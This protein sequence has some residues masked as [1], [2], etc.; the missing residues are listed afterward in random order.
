MGCGLGRVEGGMWS[1]GSG[2]GSEGAVGS[3]RR[4]LGLMV[5]VRVGGVEGGCV[6]L[7][8]RGPG[9]LFFSNPSYH[10]LVQRF[11]INKLPY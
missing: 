7:N 1:G 6:F 9:N 10:L 3:G 2:R 8:T 11:L 5:G 4:E